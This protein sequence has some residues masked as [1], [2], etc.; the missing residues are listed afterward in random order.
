MYGLHLNKRRCNALLLPSLAQTATLQPRTMAMQTAI[1]PARTPPTR[2]RWQEASIL[3]IIPIVS[4]F[5][6][7]VT[8]HVVPVLPGATNGKKNNGLHQMRYGDTLPL[9]RVGMIS[10]SPGKVWAESLLYG[11]K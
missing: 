10:L 7:G 6:A 8:P 11:C 2:V 3:S 9:L 4:L 1:S 5:S